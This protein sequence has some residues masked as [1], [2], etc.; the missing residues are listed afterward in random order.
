MRR[1]KKKLVR[2]I[3]CL[4]SVGSSVL[5]TNCTLDGGLPNILGICALGVFDCV[6]T[7][8]GDGGGPSGATCTLDNPNCNDANLGNNP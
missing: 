1:S 7:V 2:S 5:V 3:L 6:D 8:A 4:A